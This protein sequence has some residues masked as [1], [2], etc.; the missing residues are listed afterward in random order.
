ML[1]KYIISI[2]QIKNYFYFLF[3]VKAI[4]INHLLRNLIEDYL[5]NM[6]IYSSLEL[7]VL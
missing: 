4:F 1:N 2:T 5:Y 3:A 6:V 7:C